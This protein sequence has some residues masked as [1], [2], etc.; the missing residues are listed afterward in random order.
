[1]ERLLIE[2]DDARLYNVTL[3]STSTLL[4]C[5][6]GSPLASGAAALLAQGRDPAT[7]LTMRVRGRDHDAYAAGSIGDWARSSA[8]ATP[9]PL[10][11]APWVP[12]PH[13]GGS[14]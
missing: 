14:A 13:E 2:M 12:L 6:T 9:H 3:E 4:V 10:R 7:L 5:G 8:D 1:M 11:R